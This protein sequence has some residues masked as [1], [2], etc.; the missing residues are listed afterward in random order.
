RGVRWPAGALG[1]GRPGQRADAR[2]PADARVLPPA[3]AARRAA[4][5]R[6]RRRGAGVSLVAAFRWRRALHR[7]A[8]LTFLHRAHPLLAGG[9]RSGLDLLVDTELRQRRS[10]EH[11]DRE[12]H[13]R[14]AWVVGDARVEQH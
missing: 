9:N 14:E 11:V 5:A 7:R 8:A 13:V 12:A 6:R 1:W 4:P 2:R 10:R 3:L